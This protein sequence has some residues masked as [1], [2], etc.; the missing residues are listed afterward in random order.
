MACPWRGPLTGS[1]TFG[2]ERSYDGARRLT[3]STYLLPA[4]F[5]FG[6]LLSCFNWQKLLVLPVKAI[7]VFRA[8]F[9]RADR[10]PGELYGLGG[11]ARAVFVLRRSL[12]QALFGGFWLVLRH[13]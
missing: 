4:S 12:C 6:R 11:P 2:I 3:P 8:A 5:F 9:L 1:T 13:I 7:C 10:P